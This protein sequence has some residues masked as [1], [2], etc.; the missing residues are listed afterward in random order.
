[1]TGYGLACPVRSIGRRVLRAEGF[2]G[3][4]L[5]PPDTVW[6]SWVQTFGF[7]DRN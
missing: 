1:M 3:Q 4:G 7:L 6:T 2:V 5:G